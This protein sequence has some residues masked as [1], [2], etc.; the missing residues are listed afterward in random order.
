MKKYCLIILLLAPF[1]SLAQQHFSMNQG[2]TS[3]DG[4]FTQLPYVNVRGKLIVKVEING[5]T[6]RFIVDTGAPTMITKALFN[7][8]KPDLLHKIPVADANGAQD[9]LTV[10][11]LKNISIGSVIFNYIPTL[12]AKDSFIFDCHRVDGFIGSN[13]LRN[14]IFHISSRENKITITDQ[15]EKLKLDQKQGSD[16]ILDRAQSSAYLQVKLKGGKTGTARVLVDL[17]MEGLFDLALKHYKVFEK[18]NI[19]SQLGKSTGSSTFGL[20]G[21]GRDT[22]AYRLRLPELQV[23]GAKL[24]NISVNTTTSENSRIGSELIAYGVVTID[25][26]NKKFYFEPYAADVDVSQQAFPVSISFKDHKAVV[27]IIWDESLKGKIAVNDQ[28]IA[29]DDKDYTQITLCDF[30]TGNKLFEGKDK[31]M[32]TLEDATGTIKKLEIVKK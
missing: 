1:F 27:G 6:Y 16:L 5:K 7:A 26:K 13:L 10:V 12:V 23:N 30:I 21:L 14:S 3:Q 19:F 32:L 20:H 22:L 4:Y 2:G 25:Y 18:E 8:L 17:G 15:V 9:S 28:V 31:L 24:K 11:S 29:V